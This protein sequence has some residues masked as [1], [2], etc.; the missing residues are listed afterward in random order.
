M[1]N[2]DIILVEAVI[3]LALYRE[4]S[5]DMGIYDARGTLLGVLPKRGS[6]YLGSLLGV[7]YYVTHVIREIM[8][9]SPGEGR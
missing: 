9:K 8:A 4:A 5:S 7:H 1:A 2:Q 3:G 6:Y